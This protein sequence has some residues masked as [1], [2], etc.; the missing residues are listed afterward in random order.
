MFLRKTSQLKKIFI[1]AFAL[2]FVW[3][4]FTCIHYA[5]PVDHSNDASV[6]C[7]FSTVV[8]QVTC[9]QDSLIF[10]LLTLLVGFAW[11]ASGYPRKLTNVLF[12]KYWLPAV[13]INRPASSPLLEMF[14]KG[15][16]HP[17]LYSTV[18]S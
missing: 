3:M 5:N 9:T 14:R 15:I 11:V 13:W 7:D 2:I 12:I 17:K 10:L 1:G 18:V 4:I 6:S 8:S 16:I